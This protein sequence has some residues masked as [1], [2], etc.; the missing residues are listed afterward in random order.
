MHYVKKVTPLLVCSLREP[1]A[2]GLLPVPV[3]MLH[4]PPSSD[5]QQFAGV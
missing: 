3:P 2:I 4:S 1:V 5:P